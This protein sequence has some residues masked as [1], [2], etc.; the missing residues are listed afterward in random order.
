MTD[1]LKLL[2]YSYAVTM[3]SDSCLHSRLDYLCGYI[4]DI[5]PYDSELADSIAAKVLEVIT[6]ITERKTFEYIKDEDKYESYIV[7]CHMPFIAERITWGGSI[8]GAFWEYPIKLECC[9][10]YCEDD[11]GYEPVLGIVLPD[12][13]WI[14]FVQA[15]NAFIKEDN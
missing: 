8:R 2:N 15:M 5:H 10:L 6:A 14:L 3:C 11:D 1:Y 9:G 4:F 13:K 7:M 12:E